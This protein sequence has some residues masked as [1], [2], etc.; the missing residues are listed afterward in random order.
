MSEL[1]LVVAM[2]VGGFCFVT[3]LGTATVALCLNRRFGMRVNHRHER[4]LEVITERT[5]QEPSRIVQ[6]TSRTSKKPHKS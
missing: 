3:V 6:A 4:G 1:V 5:G 2:V